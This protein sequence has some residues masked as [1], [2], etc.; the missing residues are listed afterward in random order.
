MNDKGSCDTH[1]R[2]VLILEDEVELQEIMLKIVSS[3]G[4][5]AYGTDDGRHAIQ[6]HML[7]RFDVMFVDLAM[8]KMR[9]EEFIE[10][11]RR[12]NGGPSPFI[13]IMTGLRDVTLGSLEVDRIILKPF[14]SKTVAKVLQGS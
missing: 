6:E 4:M 14:G 2:R 5:E 11:V 7:R 9:G 12:M 13:V 8:P 10:K 3:F 1:L